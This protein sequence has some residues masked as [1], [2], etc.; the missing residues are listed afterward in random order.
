MAVRTLEFLLLAALAAL[1]WIIVSYWVIRLA[2]R[3]AMADVDR[4]RAQPPPPDPGWD[5]D[6]RP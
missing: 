2:V 5:P 4:R 3:H 1:V 6:R